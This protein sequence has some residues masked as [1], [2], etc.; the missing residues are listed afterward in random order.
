[1]AKK[2]AKAPSGLSRASQKPA[3]LDWM[4]G[5]VKKPGAFTAYCK[6]KGYGG[7]TSGCIE[8]GKAS[9]DPKVR[10]RATLAETFKKVAKEK[11]P[12][13]PK[14]PKVKRVKK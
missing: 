10:K 5:A 11:A 1:M 3:K 7:V 8:E 12:K 14:A 9:S 4:Q 6:G 13:A 2:K